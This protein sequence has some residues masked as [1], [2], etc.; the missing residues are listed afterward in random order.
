MSVSDEHISLLKRQVALV[1]DL[2]NVV[3]TQQ[4]AL[5]QLGAIDDVLQEPA[6]LDRCDSDDD[7]E[8]S[9]VAVDIRRAWTRKRPPVE[10]D[11]EELA[12]PHVEWKEPTAEERAALSKPWLA[13]MAPPSSWSW[14]DS[15]K[16]DARPAVDLQL[17]Y[18]HGYRSRGARSN[19]KWVDKTTVVFPVGAIVVV[20]NTATK[21]QKFFRGH[22]DE[23][24]AIDYNPVKRVVASGQQGRPARLCVWSIDDPSKTLIDS[25]VIQKG[26]ATVSLSPDGSRVAAVGL[27]DDHTVLVIDVEKQTQIVHE[28]GD[29]A[30]IA[31]INWNSTAGADCNNEFVTVGYRHITFWKVSEA[32]V[33]RTK[34]ALTRRGKQQNFLSIAFTPEYT[35][36]ASESGELYFFDG[37]RLRQVVDAHHG[38]VFSVVSDSKTGRVVSGGRDGFV[39]IWDR[40]TFKKIAAVDLNGEDPCS[41][42][43]SVKSVDVLGDVADSVLVGTITS[44]AYIVNHVTGTSTPL[45]S[46]HFGDVTSPSKYGELWAIAAHPTHAT[47]I[48]SACE[49]G[50]L[51]VWDLKAHAQVARSDTDLKAVSIAYSPDGKLLAV[52]F[53]NGSIGLFASSNLQLLTRVRRT[54]RRIQC[55]SFSPDGALLAAGSADSL[56]HV[57]RV[58]RDDLQ[59]QCK[60]SGSASTVIHVD[61]STDSSVI[62]T[63]SLAY[64]LKF[65]N[66][67]TG[68]EVNSSSCKDARWATFTSILGWSVQGIWPKDADGSEVNHVTVSRDS[69][70]LAV[71]ED[72]GF[73]K[74]F[75]YPCVGSGLDSKGNLQRRPES[76][77]SLGHSERVTSVVF[78]ADDRRVISC[79]ASDNAIMVWRVVSK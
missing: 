79:G 58:S 63:C 3:A 7:A 71:A 68:D 57:F 32:S 56:C 9:Q 40:K 69:K 33:T 14:E 16:R 12:V 6:V 35:V 5:A 34:G 30:R 60:L 26:I 76:V 74:I 44:S 37:Q 10:V 28:R 54:R 78:T 42:T 59:Y 22:D 62:Q 8:W 36:V 2:K 53:D 31:D 21:E 72:S 65:Y 43:N 13:A 75:N 25:R 17:E 52:G 55:I 4:R 23:V 67:A 1:Q 61:F 15:A 73:V 66:A 27:D 47:T 24:T 38:A 77:A 70:L 50:T 41:G 39:N 19:L 20:M 49:D 18:V 29:S 11:A 46:N 45:F 64:E 51:R 48:A